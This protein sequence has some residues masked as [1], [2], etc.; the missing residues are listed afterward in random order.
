MTASTAAK[1]RPSTAC[2]RSGSS[3]I[4]PC[5]YSRKAAPAWLYIRQDVRQAEGH[6]TQ[7]TGEDA[8][9]LHH[10]ARSRGVIT[11]TDRL[12]GPTDDGRAGQPIVAT[13]YHPEAS[14]SSRGGDS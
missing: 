9:I 7:L 6:P 10:L 4:E 8:F 2:A 13:P 11:V 5:R 1:Q 14:R 12:D 3:G